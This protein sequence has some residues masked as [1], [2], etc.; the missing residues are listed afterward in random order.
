MIRK[1]RGAA[2]LLSLMV[3]GGAAAQRRLECFEHAQTGLQVGVADA[4][5]QAPAQFHQHVLDLLAQ[6]VAGVGQVQGFGAAV[7]R[8]FAPLHQAGGDQL[9]EHPHQGR[10]FDPQGLGQ[11][12]LAHAVTEPAGQDHGPGG[13]L[14]QAVVGQG[15]VGRA[16]IGARQHHQVGGGGHELGVGGGFHGNRLYPIY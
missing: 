1:L 12:A 15:L 14:R 11:R 4:V 16:T 13:G 3:A 2:A 5:E 9:V 8:V 6:G 10:A 7:V